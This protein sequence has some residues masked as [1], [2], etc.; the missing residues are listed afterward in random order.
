MGIHWSYQH[1][2]HACSPQLTHVP[3]VSFTPFFSEMYGIPGFSNVTGLMVD[4][5]AQV[6]VD[7][8]KTIS[9]STGVAPRFGTFDAY[10]MTADDVP[11]V[12]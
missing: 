4:R 12:I 8:G 2:D 11:K 5:N 1:L 3:Q 6:A 10:I 7:L 9:S